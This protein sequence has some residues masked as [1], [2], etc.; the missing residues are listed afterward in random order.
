MQ[1]PEIFSFGLPLYVTMGVT[2]FLFIYFRHKAFLMFFQQEEYDAARFPSWIVTKCAF[3]KRASTVIIIGHLIN[4]ILFISAANESLSAGLF[5]LV[6]FLWGAQVSHKALKNA[7]KPLVMTVRA[8]RILWLSILLA[9]AAIGTVLLISPSILRGGWAM[10]VLALV[11]LQ[12]PP[13]LIMFANNLLGPAERRIKKKYL[14]EAKARLKELNPTVIGITGSYGKTSTKHMLAHILSTGAPTLATPGSVNT[15]MGITRI[16]RED[17]NP[18]HKYFI[19]EMGAYG[20][21]SIKRLCQLAP[22][23]V[24]IMTGIGLAHRERFG[25]LENVTR[26]KFELA[27]AVEQN[28][29]RCII[30]A[31][32]I[33]ASA[34]EARVVTK[35]EL[36]ITAGENIAHNKVF[37]WSISDIQ[38]SRD[39]LTFNLTYTDN[40]AAKTMAISTPVFG[41]HQ[42]ENIML[43]VA[44]AM[45]LGFPSET[46]KAALRT[47]PQTKHRLELFKS[48]TTAWVLDDAY[49]S[50]PTGFKEALKT[51]NAITDTS[52]GK[53]I[54]VTPG[55]VELGGEHDRQ[56]EDIGRLAAENTDLCLLVT[57][58]RIPSFVRGFDSVT[59][60]TAKL[61]TFSLQADA[62][63]RAREIATKGDVILFENNL[64]DLFEADVRF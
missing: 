52:A 56:H 53:R 47:L 6:A 45:H 3:D 44:T 49:N 5:Y 20:E 15:E 50:N 7:K 46:I 26:A 13:L 19:A 39:G 63:A 14:N 22:P 62:E 23:N 64:P 34:L 37:D 12:L 21:G 51:L 61:E 41:E 40:G 54:L 17:L 24:G 4:F 30:N 28:Q 25:S 32:R 33:P 59:N 8:K 55:M 57:P 58:E 38:T 31:S 60:S 16:I 27:D 18:Q 36:F 11:I 42:A 9:I 48:E 2:L 35:P 43:V 10:A 1:M 29:G